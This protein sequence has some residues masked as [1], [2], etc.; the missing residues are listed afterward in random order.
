MS[1]EDDKATTRGGK[2]D[3]PVLAT[4]EQFVAYLQRAMGLNKMPVIQP[5]PRDVTLPLFDERNKSHEGNQTFLREI[6]SVHEEAFRE[7]GGDV[8]LTVEAKTK[9]G[10]VFWEKASGGSLHVVEDCKRIVQVV[11]SELLS[12]DVYL[13]LSHQN[14]ANLPGNKSFAPIFNKEIDLVMN[15][16]KEDQDQAADQS[17]ERCVS[18]VHDRGGNFRQPEGTDWDVIAT[19]RIVEEKQVL[20]KIKQSLLMGGKIPA[21]F[22][23]PDGKASESLPD[24][25]DEPE[26][27]KE[28]TESDETE[29][30]PSSGPNTEDGGDDDSDDEYVADPDESNEENDTVSENEDTN[31]DNNL[32]SGDSQYADND[33]E[34]EEEHDSPEDEHADN[35]SHPDSQEEEDAEQGDNDDVDEESAHHN[36]M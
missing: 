35:D 9:V 21:P 5:A 20:R 29:H 28:T 7:S 24:D 11:E 16:K 8:S 27:D 23:Q 6:S 34:E 10:T 33:G 19:H 31:E 2:R 3:V 14:T 12:V 4:G 30:H 26:D 32:A 25:A 17:A 13:P 22:S 15:C 18:F 36:G 1:H